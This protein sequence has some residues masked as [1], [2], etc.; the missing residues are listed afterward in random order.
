MAII[1][2]IFFLLFIQVCINNLNIFVA[3]PII[4]LTPCFLF[5]EVGNNT[6]K[7][8]LELGRNNH[9]IIFQ[10]ILIFISV[11]CFLL[12]LFIY[13]DKFSEDKLKNI[14]IFTLQIT[15]CCLPLLFMHFFVLAPVIAFLM[16]SILFIL[17]INKITNNFISKTQSK[18]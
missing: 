13:D 17:F 15:I 1:G 16:Y 6:Y 9:S 11:F 18:Q 12:L 10:L 7:F 14:F 5:S 8:L 2:L 4:I 3:V